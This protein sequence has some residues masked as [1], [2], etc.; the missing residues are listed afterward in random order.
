MAVDWERVVDEIKS[1]FIPICTA[2]EEELESER[3]LATV[4]FTDI[5]GS[6]ARVA[7]LGDRGWREL[8][9]EHHAAIRRELSRFRRN[10]IDTAGDGFFASFD[11]PARAIRCARAIAESVHELGIDVRAGLHTGECELVDGMVAG[12]AVNIGSRVALRPHRVKYFSQ[13]VKTLS[14]DQG[15]C[16]TSV[17]R[18]S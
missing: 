18:P 10:E 2:P 12:I 16:S 8:L 14:P 7:E 9:E 3:V 4:L 1:F 17:G 5:V 11:G 6:T 15:S 13:T